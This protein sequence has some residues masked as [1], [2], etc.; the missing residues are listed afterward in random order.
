MLLSENMKISEI[1]VGCA[2]CVPFCPTEAISALGKAEIDGDKCTECGN[3]INYC[4]LGAI[5]E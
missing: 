4:P 3:C 2:G 1:C 5:V